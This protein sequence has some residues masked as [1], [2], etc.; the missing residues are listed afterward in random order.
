MI[1]LGPRSR[2]GG[3]LVD[4]LRER[5]T[6]RNRYMETIPPFLYPTVEGNYGD[7]IPLFHWKFSQLRI[8]AENECKILPKARVICKNNDILFERSNPKIVSL[9]CVIFVPT[10]LLASFEILG[11][12]LLDCL[13]LSR[14]REREREREREKE[15][16]KELPIRKHDSRSDWNGL[17]K[18]GVLREIVTRVGKRERSLKAMICTVFNC[19]VELTSARSRGCFRSRYFSNYC[20]IK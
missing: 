10:F 2:K 13:Q 17:A 11:R 14:Q 1:K 4:H 20:L 6:F 7:S 9:R 3:T 19:Y 15:R 5:A 16:E 12:T 8:R 18:I